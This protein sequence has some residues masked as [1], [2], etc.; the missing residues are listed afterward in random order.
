MNTMIRKSSKEVKFRNSLIFKMNVLLGFAVVVTIIV[1]ECIAVPNMFN[2]IK[3]V[4]QNYMLSEADINGKGIDR[5]ITKSGE[6]ILQDQDYVKSVISNIK[7]IGDDTSYAYLVDKDGT[8]IYHPT[9]TKIGQP[10]EN[11]VVK[12]VVEEIKS[13]KIPEEAVTAYDFNGTQKYAAYYVGQDYNYI[14]VVAVDEQN[15]MSPVDQLRNKLLISGLI[16]YLC[17]VVIGVIMIRKMVNPII[18]MTGNID[19]FSNL[20]FEKDDENEKC[21]TNKDE[22]GVMSRAISNLRREL[23]KII[24]EINNAGHNLEKENENFSTKFDEI[25]SNVSNINVAVEEI[26]Q[27]STSQA[28]ETNTASEKVRGIGDVIDTNIESI[29][30]MEQAVKRMDI[31]ASQADSVVKSLSEINNRTKENIENVTD[32]T[33]KTN[34]SANKINEAVQLI[35]DIAGQTNLLSLNASIEAAR[36]GEQGKG[37]AVVAEEIRKLAENSA[38]SAKEIDGIV[39]ELIINSDENVGKM[40]EVNQASIDEEGRLGDTEEAFENLKA[41][42]ELVSD[43]S[44]EIYE[45]TQKLDTLKKDVNTVV[46]QLAAISQE[47]AAATEETSASMQTLADAVEECRKAT[48]K[49]QELSANMEQQTLKFKF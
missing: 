3:Q 46:E 37:F 4:T 9:A 34:D 24:D 22:T 32:K 44:H 5:A 19:K 14:L 8:M 30:M 16:I 13:G 17:M 43:V 45:Q 6:E 26:A 33:Q 10:V 21:N 28:E 1:V 39:H 11:S 31:L 47:N 38:A 29:E 7:V 40:K 49:L 25:A 48:G 41:E 42:I 12:G 2:S 36:A 15:V 35:Q 27:G 23:A 20:D 18:I